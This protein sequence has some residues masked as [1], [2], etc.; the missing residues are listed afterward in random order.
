MFTLHARGG[1]TCVHARKQASKRPWCAIVSPTPSSVRACADERR[2][3]QVD[4]HTAHVRDAL[5]G[6]LSIDHAMGSGPF[7]LFVGAGA[8]ASS[9]PPG[10][11]LATF[12]SLT[13]PATAQAEH[14]WQA[15]AESPDS[16]A[17][18]PATAIDRRLLS[19]SDEKEELSDTIE[20]TESESRVLF[21][22][23]KQQHSQW[24]VRAVCALPLP[25]WLTGYGGDPNARY[26]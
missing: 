15:G 5:T 14:I 7:Y 13:I 8:S 2:R 4:R 3:W 22:Q 26:P 25:E 12:V 9:A 10:A 16:P 19:W 18:A 17:P 1:S 21:K 6:A 20:Q 24:K 11:K 23:L